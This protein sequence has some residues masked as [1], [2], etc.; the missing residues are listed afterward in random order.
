MQTVIRGQ[1]VAKR[2]DPERQGQPPEPPFARVAAMLKAFRKRAGLTQEQ[3]APLVGL[4]FAGYRPYERGERD[5]TM[6]QIEAFAQ[7]FGVP[8]SEITRFLWPDDVR[9]VETRYSH[10]WDEIQRQVEHLPE[11]QRERVLRAFRD[12]VEIAYGTSDLAR[13]N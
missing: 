5:L 1:V 6:V 11:A 7:A 10:Q 12:S 8:V 3:I 2:T 13:R 4:S 9:L